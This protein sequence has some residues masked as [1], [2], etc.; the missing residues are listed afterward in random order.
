VDQDELLKDNEKDKLCILDLVFIST[1]FRCS[2]IMFLL[3]DN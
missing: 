1:V 2:Y 3:N